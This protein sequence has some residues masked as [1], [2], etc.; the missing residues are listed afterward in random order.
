M[1][2]SIF[3]MPILE[4][5]SVVVALLLDDELEELELVDEELLAVTSS[6]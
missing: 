4:E 6:L 5:Q 3:S 2:Q 1:R